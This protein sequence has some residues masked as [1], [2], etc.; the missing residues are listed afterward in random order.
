MLHWMPEVPNPT[1]WYE[2][3]TISLADGEGSLSLEN[4]EA[5]VKVRGNWTTSYDKKPLRIKFD[6]KQNLLGLNGGKEFKDWVL[7]ATY[8][9]WSQLRDATAFYASKLLSADYTSDFSL[10]EV[11]VNSEY[12]GVY[13]LAE[14]QQVKKGRIDIAEAK[15][16]YKGSDIGYLIEF[17]GY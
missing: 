1:P 17:D 8:K 5:K 15:K 4:L 2:K 13:L 7:L 6:K 10:V 11:Y 12:W 14:Q 3:C 16:D 9:D